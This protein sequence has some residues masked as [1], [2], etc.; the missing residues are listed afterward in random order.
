MPRPRNTLLHLAALQDAGRGRPA[1]MTRLL[2]MRILLLTLAHASL[3]V[4]A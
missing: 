2:L 1:W 3:A 4:S